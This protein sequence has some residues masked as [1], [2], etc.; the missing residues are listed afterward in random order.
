VYAKVQ[1]LLDE[2]SHISSFDEHTTK[3]DELR[4]EIDESFQK[5]NELG[6]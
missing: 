4:E 3:W 2:R 1:S 6:R 5:M